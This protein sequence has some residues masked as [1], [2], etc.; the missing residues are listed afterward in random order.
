MKPRD[1]KLKLLDS[2]FTIA[3]PG[4]NPESYRIWEACEAGSIPVLEDLDPDAPVNSCIG[5]YDV[6]RKTDAPFL[7]IK[8]W[9]EID[10]ILCNL[11]KDRQGLWDW[12]RRLSKWYQSFKTYLII[13]FE[14]NLARY[15]GDDLEEE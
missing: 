13:T 7:Y 14:R 11:L 9:T 15:F 10:S 12:Q 5:S 4:V 3:P 1:Y 8:N 6:F 2:V